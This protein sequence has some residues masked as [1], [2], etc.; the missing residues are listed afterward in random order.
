M[1]IPRVFLALT[2]FAALLLALAATAYASTALQIPSIPHA[3]AGRDDCLSC[4]GTGKVKPAPANHAGRDNGVCKGC[5]QPSANAGGDVPNIPHDTKGREDCLVCHD[6]GKV[7]PF[8]KD[9]AGRTKETCLTCHQARSSGS[10]AATPAVTSGPTA[11][12]KTVP[13]PIHEPVL[14]EQ[15]TCIACHEKMGGNYAA[16]TKDW[17]ASAH[18]AQG[19]GCVSCHGGDPTKADAKAAMSPAAGFLGR[20]TKERIPALCGSCHTRVDLMRP[21]GITTDQLDQYWE[22]KH[23]EGLLAGDKNVA[24]CFDCHDGHRVLK[25]S[26]PGSSVYPTNQ[27][28]MCAAC[29]ANASRMASYKIPTNQY[30]L[31]RGSIHGTRLLKEQNL[32]AP[33]CSTCHGKHGAAPPGAKD[34]A[35]VCGQCHSATEKYYLQGAHR[36]GA[37]GGQSPRCI[38]CHGWHDIALSTRELY[39]G[40]GPRQCG[41]CHAAGSAA[42]QKVSDISTSLLA[43]DDAYAAA[44]ADIKKAADLRLIVTDLEEQLQKGLTPLIESRALQHTVN[45]ADIQAKAKESLDISTQVKTSTAEEVRQID[46]RRIGMAVALGF[47][48]ITIVALVLIK[49]TLDADLEAQRAHKKGRAAG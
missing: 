11:S 14:F 39:T 48:L 45:V 46:T 18:A 36:T 12:P 13:T 21:F 30:D 32:R 4:H 31:Y 35:N 38:T 43:A 7:K 23:G 3:T 24:T 33:T 2:V 47:I 20:V 29:H 5:H 1:R 10:A 19:V 6:A 9:H 40:A 15:N 42:A 22:S 28:A 49:R 25:V 34:V 16:I 27:P 17:N 26:D 37:T 8:P 41:S 44:E